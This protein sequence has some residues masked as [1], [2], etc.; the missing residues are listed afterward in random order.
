MSQLNYALLRSRHKVNIE[1]VLNIVGDMI[2]IYVEMKDT[3]S[4]EILRII[5]CLVIHI[6]ICVHD[7]PSQEVYR[8]M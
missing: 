5:S 3:F 8:F 4:F 1:S 6:G 2:L 7:V